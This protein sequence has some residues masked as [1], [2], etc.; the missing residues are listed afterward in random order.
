MAKDKEFERKYK[1]EG[2]R[3][4]HLRK[5]QRIVKFDYNRKRRYPQDDYCCPKCGLGTYYCSSNED[6][7]YTCPDCNYKF[8]TPDV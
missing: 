3:R 8:E 6:Y 2:Q 1:V 4:N 5:I 7:S